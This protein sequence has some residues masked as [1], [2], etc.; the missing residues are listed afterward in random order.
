MNTNYFNTGKLFLHGECVDIEK[1]VWNEHPTFKGVF[2]KHLIKGEST[3]N[4]LS[5]HIV[6]INPGCEIGLH[7]HVGKDELHEILDGHGHCMIEEMNILYK[8]RSRWIN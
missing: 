1:L 4:R 2:L 8:K 6:K 7:N 3:D 5:C